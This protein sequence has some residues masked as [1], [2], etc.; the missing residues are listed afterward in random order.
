MAKAAEVIVT[1]DVEPALSWSRTT[2]RWTCCTARSSA[3]DG[4]PLEARHR[5]GLDV[6]LLGRYYE[7]SPT[8]RSGR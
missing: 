6:T 7:R 1:Q 8:T 5:D 3:P 4:R 2:T